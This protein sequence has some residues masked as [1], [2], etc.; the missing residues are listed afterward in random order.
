MQKMHSLSKEEIVE[1]EEALKSKTTKYFYD[2]D[3]N[4]YWYS[5]ADMKKHYTKMEG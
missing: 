5:R 3:G 2:E 4:E 1:R